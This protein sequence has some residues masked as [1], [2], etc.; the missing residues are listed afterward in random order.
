MD[1]IEW[2]D[3]EPKYKFEESSLPSFYANYP[4][5]EEVYEPAEDSYLLTDCLKKEIEN[6][7]FPSGNIKSIEVGFLANKVRKRFCQF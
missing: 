5:F 3:L 2:N 6:T 4:D 7:A 1:K